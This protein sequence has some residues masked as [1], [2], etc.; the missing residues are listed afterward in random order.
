M[1]FTELRERTDQQFDMI[2]VRHDSDEIL[3]AVPIPGA[4]HLHYM[5][6]ETGETIILDPMDDWMDAWEEYVSTL[7]NHR[8]R[9]R[10]LAGKTDK[11][12]DN[13]P[14]ITLYPWENSMTMRHDLGNGFVL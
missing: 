3:F 1:T 12:P 13:L 6:T 8:C 11:L 9:T 4:S 10:Q 7:P 2:A 5:T 14:T